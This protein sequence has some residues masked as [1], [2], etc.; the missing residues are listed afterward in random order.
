[1]SLGFFISCMI[2]GAMIVVAWQVW[3]IWVLLWRPGL[4]RPWRHAWVW[5]DASALVGQRTPYWECERCVTQA[6]REPWRLWLRRCWFGHDWAFG[7]DLANELCWECRKCQLPMWNARL[8][9]RV[10]RRLARG[11]RMLRLPGARMLDRWASDVGLVLYT[12]RPGTLHVALWLLRGAPVAVSDGMRVPRG[13]GAAR[14]DLARMM[15]ICL[16]VPLNVAYAAIWWAWW[17]VLVRPALVRRRAVQEQELRARDDELQALVIR[18]R[19]ELEA[20]HAVERQLAQESAAREITFE[21]PRGGNS[22]HE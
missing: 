1:M 7:R 18:A 21:L 15:T 4:C 9:C 19:L 2:G 11:F 5:V 3:T 14:Y 10:L 6:S 22:P 20:G 12:G 16:P 17:R 8:S 13:Y